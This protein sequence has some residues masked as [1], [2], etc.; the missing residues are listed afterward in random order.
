M[1]A[2]PFQRLGFV[3]R[4]HAVERGVPR[5][6]LCAHSMVLMAAACAFC[7]QSR[8]P[9]SSTTQIVT[10]RPS[11]RAAAYASATIV[12]MAARFRYF[13]LGSS[14]LDIGAP[15]PTI[16]PSNLS[17]RADPANGSLRLG[18]HDAA[19]GISQPR[20]CNCFGRA[21]SD[22]SDFALPVRGFNSR[23]PFARLV[24]VT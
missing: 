10:S 18:P 23:L 9:H 16:K 6:F 4:G 21:R 3:F 8:L 12:L 17:T 20:I 24:R 13:F 15:I 19:P 2:F 14:A 11:R 5:L 7:R 1:S 22:Y